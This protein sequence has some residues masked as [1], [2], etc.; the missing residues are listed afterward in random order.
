MYLRHAF[1]ITDDYLNFYVTDMSYVQWYVDLIFRAFRAH[2]SALLVYCLDNSF[3]GK[4]SGRTQKATG[5]DILLQVLYYGVWSW[6]INKV[7][8][9]SGGEIMNY[10]L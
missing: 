2:T 1:L 10:G 8:N 9:D 6:F 5:S 4:I 7:D 3:F